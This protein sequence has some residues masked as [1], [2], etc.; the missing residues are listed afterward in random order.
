[1]PENAAKFERLSR[2]ISKAFASLLD[3]SLLRR[4][5]FR[6]TKIFFIVIYVLNLFR[7]SDEAIVR[8][9]AFLSL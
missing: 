5:D 1:M 6:Y 3:F 7:A 9:L 2:D 8:A 4:G